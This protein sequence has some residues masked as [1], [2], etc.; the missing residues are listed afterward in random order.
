MARIKLVYL[1]GGSTRA[2]GTMASFMANGADFDGSEVVLVDLDEERLALI[3]TLA[4]KMAQ[5]ARA[6]HR[7]HRHDR[8]R[9]R[10]SPT[11]TPCSRPSGR[12][13]SQARVLDERIPLEHGADRPGDAGRRRLLHGPARD[14]RAQGRLRGDGGGLP[15]RVDLQLHEPGQHRRRGD[16][17]PLADQDRLALRGADLLRERDRASR[18]GSIPTRLQRHDGR[19]QPRLLGRRARA[20]TAHDPLPLLEAAWERRRDDPSLEPRRRRQLQLAVAM[21]ADP[22]RLLRVLLLHRRG[23]GRAPR[24]ADDARR[25]HPRLVAGLLAPLRGAGTER[26]P[27]ARPGPARAAASTSS[28]SRST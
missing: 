3:R 7:R 8:P 25:G 12:A 5:R 11:A 22:R 20:T 14:Q 17:A 19:P 6:R 27:A 21:G 13:A 24:Q 16:H 2:A 15:G 4:E 18:P 23:A 26:R 1:G 9:A 28:S 10:R